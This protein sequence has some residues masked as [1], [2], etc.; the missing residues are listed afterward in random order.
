MDK[1][2]E[3]ILYYQ[4]SYDLDPTPGVAYSIANCYN[5]LGNNIEALAIIDRQLEEDS[6]DYN[7]LG[8]KIKVLNEMERL[9]EALALAKKCVDYYPD[10]SFIY[11]QRG[12]L[13]EY[14]S[15]TDAAFDDFNTSILLGS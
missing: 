11:L 15:N 1:Y 8:M 5:E 13:Y 12:F 2:K 4:K 6:L 9:D 14:F 3:A 7:F 10:D